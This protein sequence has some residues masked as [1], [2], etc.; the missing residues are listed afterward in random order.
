MSAG[1]AAPEGAPVV[2]V[3]RVSHYYGEGDS[4]NQVLFGNSIEIGPGQL[5]I[6]TGPSGS[7]KTTLLSLI[8]ALR[9]VQ[10]GTIRILERNLTGLPRQELVLVRRNLGFIFQAH[11]LF[12]SLS[13]YENVKMAMAL[14]DCPASTMREQAMAMLERL[15]IGHRADYKPRSLSGGQR[16]RVAVARALV[17]RP[18]LVLAD[19]PTAS[20]D[21]ES[22]STVVNLLKELTVGE[23]CTV[24]MVTHDSRLLDL[25]DRIVNMVDGSI[26]SDVVLRDALFVCEFLK[27]VEL[28]NRLTPSEIA[29]VAERMRRRRYAPGEIVIRQGEIGKEFFL[30]RSGTAAV[31]LGKP[32]EP[33]RRI[34]VLGTGQV[35]GEMALFTGEPRNATVRALDE[36]ETFYLRK[37][38]FEEALAF[39]TGFKDQIR[40]SYFNRLEALSG[41]HPTQGAR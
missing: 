32:G 7:G 24:I 2:H 23:G 34:A 4:R 35:V 22:S 30:I 14:G 20:L 17:N 28:F 8:G 9:S 11:N 29:N 40:Q 12:D 39:S 18:K 3:E 19:E 27:T 10:E 33:E 16:Q 41:S 21:K 26:V 37:Q 38:D 6:M 31:T 15:G 1:S 5:V 36:L 25:A 13:V